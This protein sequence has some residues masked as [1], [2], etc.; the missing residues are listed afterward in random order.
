MAVPPQLAPGTTLGRYVIE[1]LIGSGGMGAVYAA[2]D[3]AVDRS[4]AIKVLH[5]VAHDV[6]WRERF[7]T[8]LRILG[9]IDNEHVVRVYDFGEANDLLYL[10]TEL[11]HGEDLSQAIAAGHLAGIE[12]KL[13]VA[14]QIASALRD[15]HAAGIVHRDLKPANI[16]ID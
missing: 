11:L 10:V 5:S 13:D 6:E 3:P 4:V 12:R 14:R 7:F 15:V 8:E 1:R 2:R 9:K 16:F